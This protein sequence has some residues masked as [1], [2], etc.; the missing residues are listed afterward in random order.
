MHKAV[1]IT[2]LDKQY[3]FR[4]PKGQEQELKQAAHALEDKLA[5]TKQNSLLQGNEDI[6]LVTALNMCHELTMLQQKLTEKE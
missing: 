3:S 1:S 5:Q 4:C 6:L 2:L